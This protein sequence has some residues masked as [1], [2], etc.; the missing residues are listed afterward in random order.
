MATVIT[1]IFDNPDMADQ[2][3]HQL[4]G[5]SISLYSF[6][7]QPARPDRAVREIPPMPVPFAVPFQNNIGAFSVPAFMPAPLT[8]PPVRE[9]AGSPE[10]LFTATVPDGDADRVRSMLTSAHGRKVR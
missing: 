9:T 4:R 7:I 5:H 3:L 10:V 6:H 1:A 2:A 8:T